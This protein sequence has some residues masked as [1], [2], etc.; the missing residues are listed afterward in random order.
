MPEFKRT[1]GQRCGEK[2]G[3][4]VVANTV[5]AIRDIFRITRFLTAEICG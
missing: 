1:Y 3:M 4:A 2:T 5:N